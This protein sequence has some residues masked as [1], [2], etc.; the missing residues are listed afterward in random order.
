MLQTA[1]SYSGERGKRC[2]RGIGLMR[3]K[4]EKKKIGFHSC[5]R[6]EGS[7]L[8]SE[9]AK[10]AWREDKDRPHCPGTCVRLCATEGRVCVFA[11]F[12]STSYAQRQGKELQKA[13]ILIF[14][15][16]I[17]MLC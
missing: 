11:A 4:T 17:K 12:L 1:F 15:V 6:L 13:A 8:L 7:L 16:L 2:D 3:Q 14:R 5:V 9:R 10:H